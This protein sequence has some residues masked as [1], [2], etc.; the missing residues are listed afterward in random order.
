MTN[1]T[2]YTGEALKTKADAE[3]LGVESAYIPSKSLVA[4]VNLALILKRPLLVKGEPG[5]GKSTL[6]K[7]V[8]AEFFGKDYKGNYFEWNVKSTSK[9]QEGLYTI[10]HLERLSEANLNTG[11]EKLKIE[12]KSNGDGTYKASGQFIELGPLGQAF[13]RS[14]KEG[15]VAPQVMLIDEIDKADIDFPN[16]LLWELDRME[17][18]IPEIKG[19]DT[20]I[21]TANKNL[22]PLVIITSND[23]KPLPAAFLRR[24]LFH[25][26]GFEDIQ[27]KEILKAQ[28]PSL[29]EALLITPALNIFEKLRKEISDKGFSN[30]NVTTAEL[31]DWMNLIAHYHA[32]STDPIEFLKDGRPIYH[33]ALLKDEESLKISLRHDS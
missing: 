1:E 8:A 24:C 32:G 3:K 21:I 12:L 33:E 14:N 18:P 9:A 10:K 22:R 30:K 23:E 25:H 2:R 5:C 28:F 27:L 19:N 4:A 31:M 6:A 15:L 13:S 11:P 29:D 17:F 20:L 7:A 26:I 16:D